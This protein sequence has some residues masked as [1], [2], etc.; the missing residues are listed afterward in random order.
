MD[1]GSGVAG[2]GCGSSS[3]CIVSACQVTGSPSNGR[4][5]GTT[6]GAGSGSIIG[7]VGIGAV[8]ILSEAFCDWLLL[9]VMS[10]IAPFYCRFWNRRGLPTASSLVSEGGLTQ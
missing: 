3:G 4:G 8:V 2:V 1:S 7:A 6:G 5:I 10:V 9:F